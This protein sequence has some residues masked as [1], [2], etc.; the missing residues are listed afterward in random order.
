MVAA[1]WTLLGLLLVS[2]LLATI[3]LS[4]AG[5]R[6]FWLPHGSPAPRLRVIECAPIAALLIGC[7]VLTVRAEPMLRYA[8]VTAEGVI[9]P[10]NYIAA[11]LAAAPKPGP[12]R[13]G[14]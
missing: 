1:R 13:T 11:V 10:A 9:V 12:D 4:R 2:G 7:A 6:H 5:V 3:A 8:R 14:Q